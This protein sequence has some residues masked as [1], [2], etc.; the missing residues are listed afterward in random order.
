MQHIVVFE[1]DDGSPA[2][3]WFATEEQARN[4]AKV[5]NDTETIRRSIYK[6]GKVN[7]ILVIE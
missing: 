2:V 6:E 5:A 7:P 3:Q 4:F 1:Y